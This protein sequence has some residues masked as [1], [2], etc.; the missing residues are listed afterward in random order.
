MNIST[1]NQNNWAENIPEGCPPD[2]AFPPQN[3]TFYRLVDAVPPEE[4]DFWSHRKL[5]P[6]RIFNASECLACSCSIISDLQSCIRIAKLPTQKN[7][8]I[9]KL[10]LPPESG[11]IKQTGGH[12]T[13]FSWWRALDFNPIPLCVEPDGTTEN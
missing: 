3:D 5:F 4:R 1:E 6:T 7:K 2:N 8:R 12:L 13:H 11:L 9:V 10:A